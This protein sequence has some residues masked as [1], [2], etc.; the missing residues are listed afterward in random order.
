MIL[1]NNPQLF[2]AMR[3]V[4]RG[5]LFALLIF[6]PLARGSVQPWA[7]TVIEMLTLFAF[8]LFLTGR[9]LAWQWQWIK[10]PLDKPIIVLLGVT[11]FSTAFS[12]HKQTSIQSFILLLNYLVL[13]Y[14]V[15]NT[16]RTRSQF[17]QL[18]YVIISV[19]VFLAVFG[20][21][22][23]FGANPFPWWEYAE[24]NYGDRLMSTFGCPNHLAGYME[25]ALPLL[26]SL[27]LL[28]F[29]PG[30]TFIL[31]YLTLLCAGHGTCS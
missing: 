9:C 12:L 14:L 7:V 10:T 15:I 4:L 24:L 18:I 26:L 17:R 31:G 28:G 23:N 20:L 2:I 19:A 25:M 29:R 30:I 5:S 11:L 21:F 13:F 1:S 16:V 27:F 6:T 8:T 22:K 3:H